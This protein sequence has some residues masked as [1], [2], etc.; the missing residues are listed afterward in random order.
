MINNATTECWTRRMREE[1]KQYNSPP[2]YVF[3]G[4][5]QVSPDLFMLFR[6]FPSPWKRNFSVRRSP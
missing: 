6:D 1:E 5:T 2:V 4:Q 3:S